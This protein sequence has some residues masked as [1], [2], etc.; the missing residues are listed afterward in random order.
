MAVVGII[1]FQDWFGGVWNEKFQDYKRL[2]KSCVRA[3]WSHML[4]SLGAF[5]FTLPVLFLAMG[6]INLT[7]LL[8]NI[9][10]VPLIPLL[11]IG[12]FVST[13]TSEWIATQEIILWM[14]NCLIG[15][16]K[17]TQEYGVQIIIEE[18]RVKWLMILL[19]SLSIWMI[20]KNKFL[21][22]SSIF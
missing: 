9:L 19:W 1:L 8:S 21:T 15:I 13:R 10:I 18:L 3:V 20:W 22:H 2:Q 17:W 5:S 11:Q 14:V 7:G 4:V 16:V 12:G 6:K